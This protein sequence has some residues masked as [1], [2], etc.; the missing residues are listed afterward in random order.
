M[1]M[2][3]TFTLFLSLLL[4]IPL[5]QA[6]KVKPGIAIGH[7]QR[8]VSLDF[9]PDG[10]F[11][12]SAGGE[13]DGLVKLW[14]TKTGRLVKTWDPAPNITGFRKSAFEVAFF[15]ESTVLVSAHGRPLQLWDFTK[16]KTTTI[17]DE[18]TNPIVSFIA[19]DDVENKTVTAFCLDP[20][21]KNILTLDTEN[22]LRVWNGKN[23]KL[24]KSFNVG[25]DKITSLAYST[26]GKL[27]IAGTQSGDLITYHVQTGQQ[28]GEKVKL[29]ND[30]VNALRTS[31]DGTLALSGSG[32][33]L[34]L[35]EVATHKT[36]KSFDNA[37]IAG[38]TADFS[39]DGKYLAFGASG[40]NPM[41]VVW[42]VGS[43][44]EPL[45]LVDT[46]EKTKHG[47]VRSVRFSVDG[48]WVLAGYYDG[49]TLMWDIETSAIAHRLEGKPREIK[50]MGFTT[51]HRHAFIVYDSEKEVMIWDGIK[52]DG[53]A[54]QGHTK[55]ALAAAFAPN[56]VFLL[57]S[58]EDKTLIKWDYLKDSILWQSGPLDNA[59]TSLVISPDE[60]YLLTTSK[61]TTANLWDL[62]K[63]KVIRSFSDHAKKVRAIDF[64]P[65]GRYALTASDDNT[66]YVYDLKSNFKKTG[67]PGQAKRINPVAFSPDGKHFLSVSCI[68][69]KIELWNI[70]KRQLEK[71]FEMKN[72]PGLPDHPFVCGFTGRP[73]F[74]PNGKHFLLPSLEGAL[75]WDI[76]NDQPTF[77]RGHSMEVRSVAFTAGGKIAVTGGYDGTLKLW[78]VNSGKQIVSIH[79]LNDYDWAAI[80]PE[81]LFDASP[82]ALH[83]MYFVQ[84]L[85]TID[86]EQLKDL[87]Y[88]PNLLPILM[89][90]KKEKLRDVGSLDALKLYPE[91]SAEIKNNKLFIDL[92]E[93]TGG[94]GKVSIFIND[95]EII[96]DACNGSKNCPPV[97]LE[98]FTNHYFSKEEE[99]GNNVITVIAYNKEGWLKSPAFDVYP[100]PKTGRGGNGPGGLQ[101]ISFA[102][103]PE[104][105]I[106]AIIIGTSN[107]KGGTISLDFP[108][109]DAEAIAT[110]IQNIGSPFFKGPVQVATLSTEIQ[111]DP[112]KWPSKSNIRSAF[113]KVADKATAEDVFFLFL[114][115]HGMTYAD[116]SVSD[117]FYLTTDCGDLNISDANRRNNF[118]IATD[119]L[120]D[121]IKKIP[122][123]KRVVIL[124]ACHS[125]RAAENLFASRSVSASQERELERLKDRTGMFVLASSESG[126]KSWEDKNLQQGLLTYSL[127]QGLDKTDGF[128]DV[129]D[130][131]N[132]ARDFVPKLAEGIAED[133]T[134]VLTVPSK[135]A[136][137]FSIGKVTPTTVIPISKKSNFIAPCLF[138]DKNELDDH[139]FL[140]N[141]M[142]E[143]LAEGL[144]TGK[145]GKMVFARSPQKKDVFAIRG[146]YEVNGE[147][148]ILNGKILQGGVHKAVFQVEGKTSDRPQVWEKK[149]TDAV[150]GVL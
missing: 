45:Y 141:L 63:M 70:E 72:Y 137:S 61:S 135:E 67:I 22:R 148:V 124:D 6:Q 117:F 121:W 118:C 81:G 38:H 112:T 120:T 115:G 80:T 106:H 40:R 30:P 142:D 84:D 27:I 54:L 32:P 16:E 59:V 132:F 89:G 82:K 107:Y 71:T 1:N 101:N 2:R 86:L 51:D 65:D 42:E 109:K 35:W 131:F 13:E 39:A 150:N 43:Q 18:E 110:S 145:L 21:R 144:V 29:H 47:N 127:L 100:F 19:P 14:E 62:A 24:V 26:D 143:H 147:Q 49:S 33:S 123:K 79:Q 93:R 77:L 48:K 94:I 138:L 119:T 69:S 41:V 140:S 104:P 130:L 53:V 76:A 105:G 9:S 98:Q 44:K 85:E 149:I 55:D 12:V 64:S 73:V 20:K 126:Q 68:H 60:K 139:L 25:S 57:T 133:Q 122:A 10:E 74:S 97:D 15:G 75:L 3:N 136:S 5:L 134:P 129:S 108:D 4:L 113:R 90:Y 34:K 31:A 78:E 103:R 66:V 96:E 7:S 46:L 17:G 114:S 146:L 28:V 116:E 52:G 36:V 11:V 50:Q 88:E 95:A 111:D 87:Y 83:Q 91:V 102:P 37:F 8:V 23:Q 92:T 58:S 56:S 125:G 99:L 128:V